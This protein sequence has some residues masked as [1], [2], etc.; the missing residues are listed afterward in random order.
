MAMNAPD[1]CAANTDGGFYKETLIDPVLLDQIMGDWNNTYN[2]VSRCTVIGR[3]VLVK[4]YPTIP[5]GECSQF[6]LKVAKGELMDKTIFKNITLKQ[7]GRRA[8]CTPSLPQSATQLGQAYVSN[9][10]RTYRLIVA[11]ATPQNSN[12]GLS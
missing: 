7:D 2:P 6:D 1:I 5:P 12:L 9:H 11:D 4:S 8:I 3:V 10:M